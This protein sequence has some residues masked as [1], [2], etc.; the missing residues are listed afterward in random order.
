MYK[1]KPHAELLDSHTKGSS[2]K[3]L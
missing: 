3:P 1:E 2:S